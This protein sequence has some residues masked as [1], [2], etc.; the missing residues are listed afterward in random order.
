VRIRV[1]ALLMLAL[2]AVVGA[3]DA[4]PDLRPGA[5]FQDCADCPEMVVIP[6]G[7]YTMGF[8]GGEPQRYE[9]PVRDIAIGYAF[10]AARHEVTNAQYAAFVAATGYPGTPG[11]CSAWNGAQRTLTRDPATSWRDPG[12]GRPPRD[13]E[14]V[15]CVSWNDAKAYVTWLA[16]RTGQRYRLLS[17]AEWE[18][19]ARAGSGT[20]TAFAWGDD[21]EQACRHANVYDASAARPD[22]PWPPTAC[23]DGF[24]GVAP[25][26]RLAPNAFGLHDVTGNVWEWV[27]DCYAMPHPADAPRDGRA[28]LAVGCDRRAVKGG[29]WRTD[30]K[31]Q[32]PTFRGRDP[33]VFLSQIFGFRVAR[34]LGAATAATAATAAGA[35]P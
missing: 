28:Q 24:A 30:V 1:H 8:D 22:I 5:S 9:G 2:P 31:R 33:A 18:H 12:Y 15:A 13:D 14:P 35:A 3:G 26:G 27:E 34:D 4:P 32:R 19:V 23:S 29:G 17:E 25:V 11:G 10:A 6:P 20:T 7:R 21:P 16:Q